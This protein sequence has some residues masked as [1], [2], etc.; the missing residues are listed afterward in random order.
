MNINNPKVGEDNRHELPQK[1]AMGISYN[2]YD[3]VIT[4]IE[5][6]KTM[7][8]ETEIH[9]G[10]EVKVFE[11]LTLRCGVR[12]NPASYSAGASFNLYDIT[13]DYAYN[14]HSTLGGTH[15]FGVGYR[16]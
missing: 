16:F 7:D 9:V 5:F 11:I 12:N 3:N 6:K 1:I 8:W 15:H 2:P 10:A 4:S 13:I 14:T